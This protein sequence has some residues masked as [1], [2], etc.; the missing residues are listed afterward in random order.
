MSRCRT[1][2]HGFALLAAWDPLWP[3]TSTDWSAHWPLLFEKSHSAR[4]PSISLK[5]NLT[6][7]TTQSYLKYK[8]LSR[9]EW[10]CSR[11]LHRRLCS[12]CRAPVASKSSL[13]FVRWVI[14]IY[15]LALPGCIQHKK[16][17]NLKSSR[18]LVATA[19]HSEGARVRI[20]VKC[21][22]SW[23]TAGGR[24]R[25]SSKGH[26]PP[27]EWQSSGGVCRRSK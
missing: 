9:R 6:S 16:N 7:S 23:F 2:M 8:T 14:Q 22:Q 20:K 21:L 12:S 18:L 4:C 3:L 17:F 26:T 19:S 5:V 10:T 27:S 11:T 13:G 25:T 15:S 1:R 24:D